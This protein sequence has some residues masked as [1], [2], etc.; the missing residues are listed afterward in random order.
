MHVDVKVREFN[1]NA[2]SYMTALHEY[3]LKR[4]LKDE[5]IHVVAFAVKITPREAKFT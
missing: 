2:Y 1:I 3:A 5:I 4:E